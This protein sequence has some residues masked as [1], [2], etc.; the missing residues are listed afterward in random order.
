M[1][2][3]PLSETSVRKDLQRKV[4]S[5]Q[6]P[7]TSR[8]NPDTAVG[9]SSTSRNNSKDLVIRANSV[10]NINMTGL[11][12]H[13]S[14]NQSVT[15]SNSS[16]ARRHNDY[17]SVSQPGERKSAIGSTTAVSNHRDI[18]AGRIRNTPATTARANDDDNRVPVSSRRSIATE[19][20]SVLTSTPTSSTSTNTEAYLSR[21]ADRWQRTSNLQKQVEERIANK[22]RED[23]RKLK[24]LNEEEDRKEQ[25][26]REQKR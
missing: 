25:L 6:Q 10:N 14:S 21:A 3:P 8:S 13:S 23:E 1:K 19:Q 16:S 17:S 24:E 2:R 15:S 22:K 18:S 5:R 9:S 20:H 11:N 12:R 26:L 7:L 4:D